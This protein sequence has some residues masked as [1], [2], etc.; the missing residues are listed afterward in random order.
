MKKS[1]QDRIR[2]DIDYARNAVDLNQRKA[3]AFKVLGAVDFA[4]EFKMISYQEWEGYVGEIF[5]FA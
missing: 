2:E 1:V 3:L 4:V 5:A